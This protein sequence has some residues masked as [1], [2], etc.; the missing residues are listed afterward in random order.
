M[1]QLPTSFPITPPA[2]SAPTGNVPLHRNDYKLYGR[3]QTCCPSSSRLW[4]FGNRTTSGVS[5]GVGRDFAT[6]PRPPVPYEYACGYLCR[7]TSAPFSSGVIAYGSLA[8]IGCRL[9]PLDLRHLSL[10]SRRLREIV[11]SKTFR[12]VWKA[13]ILSVPDI[14][15]V[16]PLANEPQYTAA[17]FGSDCMVCR[18]ISRVVTVEFLTRNYRHVGPK[19]NGEIGALLCDIARL[20]T[21]SGGLLLPAPSQSDSL[22]I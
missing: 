14:P 11:M 8:Q 1:V 18:T 12:F 21:L 6:A 20:A 22:L 4:H 17:V 7:G 9:H 19:A 15:P 5:L 16:H 3:H 13:T 2:A 10:T